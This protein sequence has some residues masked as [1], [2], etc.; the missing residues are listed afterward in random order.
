MPL[1]SQLT[2]Y[3]TLIIDNYY[4]NNVQVYLVT[5]GYNYGDGYLD[6]TE[7]L[8]ASA[9]SWTNINSAALPS[10]RAYLRGITLNNKVVVT[11]TNIDII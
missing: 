2:S 7:L 5:G 9:T 6:S 10:A 4:H 1:T 11:G 8:L 3:L